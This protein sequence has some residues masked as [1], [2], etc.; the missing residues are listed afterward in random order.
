MKTFHQQKSL[1]VVSDAIDKLFFVKNQKTWTLFLQSSEKQDVLQADVLLSVNRSPLANDLTNTRLY[2]DV[3]SIIEQGRKEAY[4]SVKHKMIETYWNI[5]R[6]IVE[7]EQKGEARAE[8]GVQIITQLS[9]QLI[10]QYGKEFSKRN[11]AYF[12]QFYL[13]ISDIRILQSRLQNLTWTHITKVLRVED[14]TA[15]RWYLEMASKE[16]WSVRTLDRNI[17]TQYFERHFVQP[18]LPMTETEPHQFELLRSPVVAEFLGFKQDDSYSEE[19]LDSAIITHLQEFMMEMGRGF[20]FMGRQQLVRTDTQDYF[21]D[22][23]FYNVVLKCYV[24]IDLKLGAITHQDVG[25]MD[26]YVRMYDELKHTE[27][28]NQPSASCFVQRRAR[29][30]HVIPSSKIMT[31]SLQQNTR[32]ICR[33][34]NSFARR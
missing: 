22:L 32:L 20:A 16:M 23:V 29:I 12:R 4:A 28:D 6:R 10:H 31:I 34:K 14:S 1:S 7:E 19:E 18:S 8:Y 13:T 24:L 5:G 33:Q 2:T 11:L 17:S 25:Q 15:I 26:M 3:C 21:I 9:E 30:L 27:G